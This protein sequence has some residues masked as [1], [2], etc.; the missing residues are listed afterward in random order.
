MNMNST[1]ASVINNQ[2]N[3][4]RVGADPRDAKNPLS[5]S[6]LTGNS[7]VNNELDDEERNSGKDFL[8][9]NAKVPLN[10]LTDD[11]E[12]NSRGDN[13]RRDSVTDKFHRTFT[14]ERI[15]SLIV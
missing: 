13:S 3:R 2:S 12:T 8:S 4:V 5:I 9:Y 1:S 10:G 7:S 14:A 11:R 6:Q 15:S